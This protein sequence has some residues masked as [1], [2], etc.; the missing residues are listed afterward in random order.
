MLTADELEHR[1]TE[2]AESADLQALLAELSRRAAPLITR[3]PPIPRTKA[4]LSADGGVCPDDGTALAFD[5][6][7]PDSHR[8]P[9]CNREWQG[10]RHHRHWAKLQ[11]LWLAERAAH[12]AAV[13]VFAGDSAAAARASELLAEYGEHYLEYPNVD[14]VLGPARLFFSTY[15]ESIWV[16]DY[17]AAAMLLRSAGLLDEAVAELVSGVADEAANL[18]ADFDEGLSNRQTWHAAALLAIALWFEDEELAERAISG[19]SG[20]AAHLA[21]GF[22]ADGMWYEGENYHLFA[23]QGFLNGVAW[24]RGAGVDLVAEAPLAERLHAALLAPCLT[25]LPDFTFPARKDSRFGVS[26]AQPMYLELWELGRGALLE[27]EEDASELGDWLH[28]LYGAPSPAAQ[29]FES[30]LHEA[31]EA[32][33]ERTR[34]SLSWRALVSMPPALGGSADAWAPATTLLAD[35]GLAVLREGGRYASLECGPYGGGHGHPDRLHLTLFAR[36]VHWL[37]DFGTGSY[38][39][40][41]L[42]WYRSTLAHNAPLA[43]GHSQEPGDAAC[44]MFD[45]GGEWSWVRGRY[46]RFART[47]VSGPDYLIDLLEFDAAGDAQ[48]A[49]P[50]HLA[51]DVLVRTPGHWEPA[52]LDNEFARGAERFVPDVAGPLVLDAVS[53]NARLTLHLDFTG[54]LLRAIAPGAPG[55]GPATFWLQ[56]ATDGATTL[57]SVI[58]TG[59][60]PA[61][62]AIRTEGRVIEVERETETDRHAP[63]TEGWTIDQPAK[64]TRLGGRQIKPIEFRPLLGA[65]TVRTSGIAASTH[66]SLAL[67]G[68]LDGFDSAHPFMLDHDDQYRRSE[69]PYPGAEE[70]S[71]TAWVNWDDAA[72]YVAVDVTK[73]NL[74]LRPAGAPPLRLD[75]EPDDIHSDGVQI[76]V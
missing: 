26:L 23:L 60:A 55:S 24:A 18:I 57:V 9:R 41:D 40:R 2:I 70:F 16:L 29:T 44:E 19:P 75:N 63:F 58:D 6:W 73:P 37:P 35:Q 1:R 56:R 4:L 67:D 51:G 10:E 12:L 68:T 14:N 61:V 13:A 34:A 11:H 43:D 36:G 15:L 45:A 54:D 69:D 5:P 59:S 42:F 62:R 32:T 39:S 27:S 33:P 46:D 66:D 72:L 64:Q 31:A 50:W 71:A 76:Y 65:R 52:A 38:V 74:Q 47:L 53:T 28:A 22:G 30:Y 7:S 49:L 21:Q 17:L 25:A 3:M 8:C 20:L 48:L